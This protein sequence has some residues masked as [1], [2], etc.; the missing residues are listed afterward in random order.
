MLRRKP[1]TPTHLEAGEYRQLAAFRYALRRF[2]RF[3][4]AAAERMGLSAQHYQAMLAL[5]AS[6]EGRLTIND[7]AQQLLIRHNS[8]V[9]LV[10]RLSKQ[11]LATR[12]PSPD[13][14]RK[15]YLRLTAKGDRVLA[16][17]VEVHR[18]ELRRIGPQLRDQLDEIAKA[19]TR[20]E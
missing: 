20:R 4:E 2:L 19:Q 3:S 11:G 15:V 16:R 18:E 13:D 1:R 9:G 6:P 10:D 5:C 17:L 12:E 14:K 8:A 7:L